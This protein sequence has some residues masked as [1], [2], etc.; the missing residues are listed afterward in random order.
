MARRGLRL[1]LRSAFREA[2]D[3]HRKA[4]RTNVGVEFDDRVQRIDITVEPLSQTDSDPLFLVL[5][6]DI[7]QPVVPGEPETQR[8][9][10]GGDDGRLDRLE[11][12]LRDSRERLQATIE[13]YETAVEEL[14]S[15]N[16]ELQSV[17]EE[18]QSSNE[19]LETSKEELQS[20]NEELHTVNSELTA[21]VDEV[22]RAN[23]DLRNIFES[24]R[25]ATV[26]LDENLVIRT[27]TPAVSEVFNL[28]STDRGRPLTD[29][30]STLED[31]DLRR[32]VRAVF[33]RGETVERN[34]RRR[35]G[36]AHYLMRILPYRA[37]GNVIE[38]VIVTFVEVTRI[39]EAEA[40]HR[41]LVEELN[42]RVRNMLAVVAAIARQTLK[43]TSS[44]EGFVEAFTSR[45]RSM[46]DAFTL[47]SNQNWN[48]VGLHDVIAKQLEPFAIGPADRLKIQ[49]GELPLN[50]TQAIAISLIVHE[51]A[52]NAVK[53]GALSNG[54][55][56]VT[57]EWTPRGEGQVELTWREQNGPPPGA[58]AKPGFG[59][60]L[61]DREVQGT[62]HGSASF[63]YAETGLTATILFPLK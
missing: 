44:P 57:V 58:P 10:P 55:G 47:V 62:L 37:H 19:E 28:I 29:I 3:G 60:E 21:K 36:K 25:I 12:E 54:E 35:D 42:H 15:S 22:D 5:F 43:R 45:I 33:E 1:D 20:L 38:G 9:Q 56:C 48:R 32:D 13:E 2:V 46:G 34:V 6:R 50:P 59:A 39:V 11:Q 16:E 31:G 41:T 8:H 17:N 24:T 27:F 4:E 51:L 53:H 26:F 40:H 7:G 18:L 14:K 52:T 49:G 61:I 23:A 63:K 30:S